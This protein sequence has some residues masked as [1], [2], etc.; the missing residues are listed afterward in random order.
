MRV[1]V[2]LSTPQALLWSG[3]HV[4]IFPILQ[5]RCWIRANYRLI[6]HVCLPGVQILLSIKLNTIFF[7]FLFWHSGSSNV[8]NP[9]CT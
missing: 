1:I 6:Y 2:G 9:C 4:L 3:K 7:V 5:V 8:H